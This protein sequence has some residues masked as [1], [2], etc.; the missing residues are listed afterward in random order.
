M[1]GDDKNVENLSKMLD[2]TLKD[3]NTRRVTD[4]DL[5]DFMA[6]YDK[7]ALQRSGEEFDTLLN[8][9]SEAKPAAPGAVPGAP[10]GDDAELSEFMDMMKRGLLQNDIS[11]MINTTVQKYDTYFAT[12]GSQMSP[13]Q[14]DLFEKQRDVLK[15]LSEQYAKNA[16]QDYSP[17][18]EEEITNLW[19]ELHELGDPP[20][21][22][23]NIKDDVQMPPEC[24]IC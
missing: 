15:K 6:D 20:E 2:E 19:K 22:L 21:H 4:D 13:E 1:S 7:Q 18:K 24:T 5:D 10:T 14:R 3:F 11:P 12:E 16:A 23:F 9:I 8:K 17:E